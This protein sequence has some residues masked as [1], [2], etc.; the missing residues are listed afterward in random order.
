MSRP[1]K[2]STNIWR[3][4]KWRM[5]QKVPSSSWIRSSTSRLFSKINIR[6][7]IKFEVIFCK[8][9][10]IPTPRAPPI[11]AKEVR[12]T[13]MV[14]RMIKKTTKYMSISISLVKIALAL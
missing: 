1:S 11:T 14:F 7:L 3:A 6:P 5:K 12:S 9:K 10:P 4:P 8:P 13:P 2:V